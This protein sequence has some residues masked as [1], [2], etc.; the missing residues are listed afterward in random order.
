M[1][2]KKYVKINTD[3]LWY[4]VMWEN[5]TRLK[6][7]KGIFH[8]IENSVI[9]LCHSSVCEH[10][11]KYVCLIFFFSFLFFFPL[12]PLKPEDSNVVLDLIYIYIYILYIYLCS[13]EE[14]FSVISTILNT[15]V[16]SLIFI[17]QQRLSNA[18]KYDYIN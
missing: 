9:I 11:L 16:Y 5:H 3:I 4:N 13:T 7:L 2:D 12:H 17:C 14:L 8:Q 1:G 10:I 15:S 18:F 6:R